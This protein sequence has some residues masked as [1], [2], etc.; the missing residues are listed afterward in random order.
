MQDFT[1]PT[2]RPAWD[3]LTRLAATLPP[4]REL[5]Q[6]PQRDRLQVSAAGIT[7]DYSRQPVNG[8]VLQ[9]LV[10]LAH[11]TGVMPQAAAMFRGDPINV[12]ENR[13]ALHVALRGSHAPEPPWGHDIARQVRKELARFTRF[14]EHVR[15]GHLRGFND[16][17]ITDIVNLGIGGSD[18]GPRV[19]VEALTPW[20]WHDRSQVRVHFVSNLD[21]WSLYATL[22][23]LDPS[24]TAFIVQS[25]SF[26]TPET[27][28]L[29]ASARRW[30][31][32]G[33]CPAHAQSRH[34][35]AVTA[36]AD[37]ALA[38]GYVPEHMFH[39]WDWVGGR[40]SL[41]SAIGL[42]LAIAIGARGFEL[43]LDGAHA[44]DTHFMTAPPAQNLPLLLALLGVWNINFMGSPTHLVAPYAFTLARFPA[45]MQ[46]L[47]MESNGKRT[48]V[49][50]SPVHCQTAPVIWGGLGMDG[51]HAYYQLLHQGQHRVPLDFIGV[52]ADP[53]PLPL[54]E[55]H[56]QMVHNNMRAQAEALA[57][58]RDEITTRQ[59]LQAQGLDADTVARLTPHR[60]YPGNN[61]SNL[62]WL[63]EMTPHHLGALIALYEHK[64][65]CQSALWGICAFDQWGVE[66]GKTLLQ[67][68]QDT[69]RT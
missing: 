16:S 27:L 46:Q 39:L 69:P 22:S 11:A 21:A 65:F 35:I 55:Q 6:A 8:T 18:L 20:A 42:P 5:M 62:L 56:H 67:S 38:A 2:E 49:D 19:G 33:G 54:A 13:P 28:T 9:H 31:Q 41:W 17:P 36:R 58:G 45:Y 15:Q 60:S 48:H 34:L 25:K 37:L 57:L 24:R 12:T 40:Y 7:L 59:V 53:T 47:D 52:R 3:D 50:G 29:A 44:M 14:A 51:Q 10:G 30:L 1:P 32:D 43:L 66:L 26:T 23:T 4:L 64:V 63:D 61:P 68:L